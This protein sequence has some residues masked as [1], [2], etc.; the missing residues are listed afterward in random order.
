MRIVDA[1]DGQNYYAQISSIVVDNV[2]Y[3]IKP[4]YLIPKEG[5]S[6]NLHFNPLRFEHGI[7]QPM[8][9]LE[10]CYFESNCPMIPRYMQLDY[11][12]MPILRERN[13]KYIQNQVKE[14]RQ[15]EADIL[16]SNSKQKIYFTDELTDSEIY[17]KPL[18]EHHFSSK[19][20]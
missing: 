3:Y 6:E 8:I 18:V 19:L 13:R 20:V 7:V 1:E 15:M 11:T 5:S 14:R 10:N 2:T 17:K 4:I 16:E 9:P 12:T